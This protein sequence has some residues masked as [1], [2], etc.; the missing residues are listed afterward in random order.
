MPAPELKRDNAVIP[1][2]AAA[3]DMKADSVGVTPDRNYKSIVLPTLQYH[4]LAI[5][6]FSHRY[7]YMNI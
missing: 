6:K 5:Y 2:H 1:N 3:L 4:P 7:P